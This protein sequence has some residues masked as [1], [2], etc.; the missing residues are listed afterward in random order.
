METE[1]EQKKTQTTYNLILTV[2]LVLKYVFT[3]F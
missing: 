1:D 3:F 2:T